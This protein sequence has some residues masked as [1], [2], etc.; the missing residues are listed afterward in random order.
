[1]IAEELSRSYARLVGDIPANFFTVNFDA[2]YDSLI[3][4]QY[5]INLE[6]G[7]DLDYHDGEK[8]IG[9]Y[10][11]KSNTIFLDA[12]LNDAND[13][14]RHKKG[15][16]FW[17]ELG[18][19]ILHGEWL[20]THSGTMETR[21]VTVENSLSSAAEKKMEQQANLFAS[22]A[23]V[24]QWFLNFVLKSTFQLT[25]PIRYIGPANY[26]LYAW[27]VR[28]E[29][30]VNSF[31]ELCRNIAYRIRHRFN[32]LSI[33]AITYRIQESD[34]VIDVQDHVN[35]G[36]TK[37]PLFRTCPLSIEGMLASA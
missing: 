8:V 10:E 32:G 33:E 15:F 30:H 17:H 20:R 26:Q 25:R 35:R 27:G 4:P 21:I 36:T 22:R 29:S 28:H 37:I 34:Y 6:E 9:Y 24:P 13:L 7:D 14:L 5:G 23:A 16:T 11:A 12:V 3:Y 2:V 18:H 31:H 1:L 19:A